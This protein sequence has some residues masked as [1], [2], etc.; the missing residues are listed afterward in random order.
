MANNPKATVEIGPKIIKSKVKSARFPLLF[1]HYNDEGDDDNDQ[2][3]DQDTQDDGDSPVLGHVN[4]S[5]VTIHT[6]L[7]WERFTLSFKITLGMELNGFQADKLADG[8]F[9]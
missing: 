4:N 9:L 5:P 7:G 1:S 6:I 8:T 3:R 2:D